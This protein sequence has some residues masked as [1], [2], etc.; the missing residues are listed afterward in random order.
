M[1]RQSQIIHDIKNS[2]EEA[3]IALKNTDKLTVNTKATTIKFLLG[4]LEANIDKNF[5]T[6]FFTNAYR[7]IHWKEE[8]DFKLLI[9]NDIPDLQIQLTVDA[10]YKE[11]VV[12]NNS[13]DSLLHVKIREL[14]GRYYRQ[15]LFRDCVLASITLLFDEI[16]LKTGLID[17]GADLL[18]RVFSSSRPLLDISNFD[19]NSKN[20]E[21]EQIGYKLMVEGLYKGVRNPKAHTREGDFNEVN[22]TQYLVFISLLFRRLDEAKIVEPR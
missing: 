13:I 22:T 11:E 1:D 18:N 21:N 9:E 19:N 5:K 7:R 17:D 16:R 10:K 14:Y 3:L 6:E 8:N 2:A 12:S 15:N 20:W 4:K